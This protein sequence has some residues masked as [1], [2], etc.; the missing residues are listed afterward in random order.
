MTTAAPDLAQYFVPGHTFD[1]DAP[2]TKGTL[3]VVPGGELWLPTGRVVACDPFT[4]LGTGEAEPFT[5]EVAPGRYRVDAAVATLTGEGEDPEGPPHLRLAAARLIISDAPTATWEPALTAGQD[6]ADLDDDEMF[7]YGVDA[8][9]GCFYDAAA[10]ESF[11]DC[12]GD[13]GP[14]WDAFDADPYNPGPYTVTAPAT[15]H[16][17]I[18]FTSGW[19]DGAYPTWLGRDADGNITCFITDFGVVP[20]DEDD[21]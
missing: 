16:N 8:G 18:A 10:D 19:G 11:P 15:G 2:G 9:T 21:A 14:L 4:C 17:L 5:A 12:Q 7:C 6:P 20:D 3:A 1:D 13:E